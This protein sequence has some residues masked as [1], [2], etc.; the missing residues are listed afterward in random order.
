MIKRLLTTLKIYSLLLFCCVPAAHALSTDKD[1]DIE[2]EANT[3]YLDDIKNISI[4]TGNVIVIQG[5]IRITGDKMTIFYTGEKDLEKIIMEGSPAT[6][7]Q[8]PDNSTVYDEAEALV[9]EFYETGNLIVL[10][11]QA[12]VSQGDRRLQAD[13][14]EYDTELSQVRAR[15]AQSGDDTP[16][17]LETEDGRVRLIIPGNRADTEQGN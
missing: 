13:Y 11:G 16:R 2:V 8:L 5:S 14:I 4:Y 1:Q 3:A 7:R 6:F 12:R 15:T 9:M 17:Q 10:T